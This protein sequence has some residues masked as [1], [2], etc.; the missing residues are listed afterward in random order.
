[1]GQAEQARK[2][3]NRMSR[4]YDIISG[5]FDRRYTDNG[6]NKLSIQPGARA[7][8]IGYGTGYAL[9]GLARAVGPSGQVSGID[10]SDKMHDLA[11]AKIK[12]LGLLEQVELK[13]GTA[14]P[15]PYASDSFDVVYLSFTL[16]LFEDRQIPQLLNECRRVLKQNGQLGIVAMST[17]GAK[18][19]ALKIYNW[20]HKT[21]PSFVDC[22]PIPAAE[23]VKQA[24]FQLAID[25][26]MN[27]WGLPVAIIAANK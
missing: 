7:L 23:M 25:Q 20:C 15:L 14:I 6:L 9:I 24:G 3:Y 2:S 26:E 10:I 13:V 8:E 22:R 18:T 16:E 12:K 5:P 17:K 27:M 1:M 21:F 11:A 19:W 4:W